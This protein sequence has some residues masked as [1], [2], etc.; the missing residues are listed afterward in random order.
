MTII[1]LNKSL[2]EKE[3]ETL[4]GGDVEVR[5]C[6][7]RSVQRRRKR[8]DTYWR[9]VAEKKKSGPL[10]SC[11]LPFA[12]PLTEIAG[13]AGPTKNSLDFTRTLRTIVLPSLTVIGRTLQ[14]I[15]ARLLRTWST[16]LT[17]FPQREDA[18]Q[19]TRS[20]LHC[21]SICCQQPDRLAL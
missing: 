19:L 4:A 18:C 16:A 6:C 3:G 14:P 13:K 1:Q 11:T 9:Q 21:G 10:Q 2:R 20:P 7:Q 15:R 5:C 12:L 17:L 8:K